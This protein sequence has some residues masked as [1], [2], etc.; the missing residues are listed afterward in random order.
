MSRSHADVKGVTV[1]IGWINNLGV[2][3]SQSLWFPGQTGKANFSITV[4]TPRLYFRKAA[5]LGLVAKYRVV[6]TPTTTS[7][8]LVDRDLSEEESGVTPFQRTTLL[9][10][11]VGG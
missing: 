4:L 11:A 8:D 9:G 2:D 3:A 10:Q 7:R 6:K 5:G 1:T